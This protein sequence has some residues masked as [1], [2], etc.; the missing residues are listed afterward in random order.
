M[1]V[2]TKGTTTEN[3]IFY[4]LKDDST[5]SSPVYLFVFTKGGVDYPVILSDQ[6]TAAQKEN[7]SLFDIVEGTD[8]PTNGEFIIGT[9]GVYDLVIYEQTSTT[10]L[11]PDAV[12]TT[13]VQGNHLARVIDSASESTSFIEHVI[14]TSYIE[15]SI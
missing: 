11:D 15:H 13:K 5:L 7:F 10:N 14:E 1:I 6:A 2:L 8:D 4:N 3:N 12:G 9:T